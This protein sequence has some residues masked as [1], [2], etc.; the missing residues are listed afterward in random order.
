MMFEAIKI[1]DILKVWT[2]CWGS[3]GKRADN[4]GGDEVP[5]GDE[6]GSRK[7]QSR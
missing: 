4:E 7:G 6:M 1:L 5:R 3:T 2:R